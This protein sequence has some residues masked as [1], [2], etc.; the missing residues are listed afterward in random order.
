MINSVNSNPMVYQAQNV[1]NQQPMQ[2]TNP[3]VTQSINNSDANLSGI[4]ALATYNQPMGQVNR[5]VLIPSPMVDL[6]PEGIKSLSGQK[7]INPNGELDSIVQQTENATV[8]YKF[9]TLH[10]DKI[11]NIKYY[12]N[13]TGKLVRIQ[14][15]NTCPATETTPERTFVD[16]DEIDVNNGRLGKITYYE[17]GNVTDVCEVQHNPDGSEIHYGYS[18]KED[19]SFISESDANC[20]HTKE[21]TFDK[22]GK[23]KSVETHNLEDYTMQKV[24]YLNGIPAK[25]KTEKQEIIPNETG[26]NPFADPRLVPSQPY[27]LGYDPHNVEGEKKYYSNGT[28]ASIETQT[29]EGNI[30]HNFAPNGDLEY[31][32]DDRNGKHLFV[33][34]YQ[35][36]YGNTQTVEEDIA[37]GVMKSTSFRPEGNTEVHI[38]NIKD[39][40]TIHA[41]FSKEGIL[42]SYYQKDK[43]GK[44]MLLSFD[45]QG[46]LRSIS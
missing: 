9:D 6:T 13:A 20:T 17:D 15:N 33:T 14:S 27:V 22:N 4:N 30:Y 29:A 35:D 28:I 3:A 39:N 31:I 43:D 46:N 25:I 12:D 26:I 7:I 45:K 23:I 16:I 37:D 19:E 42:R 36:S 5:K 8:V 34:Y 10:P 21:T 24:E 44:E 40:S 38:T 18:Y 1:Q 2:F 11:S 41:H 32:S